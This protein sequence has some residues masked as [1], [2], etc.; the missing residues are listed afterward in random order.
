MMTDKIMRRIKTGLEKYITVASRL[1][2]QPAPQSEAPVSAT[3]HVDPVS[4]AKVSG[5]IETAYLSFLGRP[6]EPEMLAKRIEA[7]EAGVPFAEMFTEIATCDEAVRRA[8][9]VD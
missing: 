4:R 6:I 1:I 7:I 9:A 8:E 2:N 3:T 5:L